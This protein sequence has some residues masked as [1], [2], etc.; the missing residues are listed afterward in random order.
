M[1]PKRPETW[2]GKPRLSRNASTA[3]CGH[4]T[5]STHW[6]W[7]ARDARRPRSPPTLAMPSG[8]ASPPSSRRAHVVQRLMEP[9]MFS[10]WGIRTLSA[11]SPCFNPQGYHVGTVWPHDNSIIA[12]GFKRYGFESELNRLATALFDAA[13]AFPYYRLPELFGGMA[14]S[15]H[16]SPVPYPVACRPQA[17]AAGAFPPCDTG[18]TGSLPGRPERSPADREAD[19]AGL[20]EVRARPRPAGGRRRG[21]PLLRA[22]RWPYERRDRRNPRPP[23]CGLHG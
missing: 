23:R 17:W 11:E 10:G 8:A 6:L 20:A 18:N 3:R 21:G 14:R 22:A 19:T 2:A 12:M 1:T 16:D 15:G 13:K 7:T 4:R 9:D 5:T